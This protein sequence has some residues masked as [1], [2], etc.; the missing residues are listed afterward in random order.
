MTNTD[1]EI[2]AFERQWWKHAVPKEQAIRELFG[3]SARRYVRLLD[4]VLDD[5]AALAAD[6]LLVRRLRR[7]RSVL[8]ASSTARYSVE[9]AGR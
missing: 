5:P 6:P 9:R 3:V 4:A 7:R 2:L 8:A 1:L